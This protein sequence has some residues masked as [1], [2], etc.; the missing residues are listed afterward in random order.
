M[1]FVNKLKEAIPY[2]VKESYAK[3]VHLNV[4]ENAFGELYSF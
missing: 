1:T 4:A 2:E 3:K